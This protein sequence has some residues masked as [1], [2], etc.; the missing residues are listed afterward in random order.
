MGEGEAVGD[1][2]TAGM[3]GRAVE[4]RAGEAVDG[5]TH[6]RACLNCGTMLAGPYCY[7]CGQRGHVHR[8]I[9]AFFHD[10]MHGVLHFEGKIWRTLPL[11][12]WRPGQLT[13]RY[14]EGQRARFVSPIALFLFSV[15][16]M[17]AVVSAMG[18]FSSPDINTS[19]KQDLAA[20]EREAVADIAAL[21]TS[22]AELVK[23]GKPTG[24][25][26]EQLKEQ[27]GT[28]EVVRTLR[29]RGLTEGI[30]KNEK[31]TFRSSI[32]WI[33]QAYLKAKQN[34]QLLLYKLKTNSY[35]WSW[36]LIPLS[37]P[38]MWLV[39]P[40]SRR[41][42]TYDH[43]VFITY[44]LCFMSLLVVLASALAYAGFGGAAPFLL[45]IPPIHIFRQLCGAYGLGWWGALW[46]TIV[47]LIAAVFVL[48]LFALLIIAVGELG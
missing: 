11:L 18:G 5:H 7:E 38:F 21:K 25:V 22:R 30:L 19:A 33:E 45:L 12:A 13:R 1:L 47:L 31:T 46:R 35:K 34:P 27:E 43:V 41:F 39:F 15:F 8:T 14:I 26:D 4:S 36:A 28:L 29:G 24:A 16:L 2:V 20:A 32:P 48:S 6:E 42:R 10:L 40:F 9:R 37:V 23:Q 44:S 3:L 17:F